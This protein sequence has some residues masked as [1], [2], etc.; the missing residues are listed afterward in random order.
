MSEEGGEGLL[1]CNGQQRRKERGASLIGCGEKRKEDESMTHVFLRDT[2]KK[3][4][5]ISSI[6]GGE[7]GD[8]AGF[9]VEVGDAGCQRD[10]PECCGVAGTGEWHGE[11]SCCR[12]TEAKLSSQDEP[13]L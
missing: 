8:A 1:E 4:K 12:A 5:I 3:I 6:N 11:Y 2:I 13:S 7:R 10:L 9:T